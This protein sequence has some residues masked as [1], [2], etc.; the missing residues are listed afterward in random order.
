MSQ[1]ELAAC[2]R[3]LATTCRSDSLLAARAQF[4]ANEVMDN[5]FTFVSL[6]Y[7]SFKME[8]TSVCP[9]GLRLRT[10][11]F[12]T[13]Q[14]RSIIAKTGLK[15]L[16]ASTQLGFTSLRVERGLTYLHFQSP[17]LLHSCQRVR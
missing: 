12:G 16:G 17:S 13:V 11:R 2:D 3:Q 15:N 1:R 4:S 14:A 8:G 5:I 6:C 9:V 7:Q 10:Y